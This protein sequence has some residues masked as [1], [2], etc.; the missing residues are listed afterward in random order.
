M[1]ENIRLIATILPKLS[2]YSKL[3]DIEYC[4]KDIS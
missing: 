1:N 4:S 2:F 3:P